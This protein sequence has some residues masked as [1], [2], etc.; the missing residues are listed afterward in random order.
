[1]QKTPR[2]VAMMGSVDKTKRIV[3]AVAATVVALAAGT[4]VR[5][6]FSSC[7]LSYAG[8]KEMGN[9]LLTSAWLNTVCILGMGTSVRRTDENVIN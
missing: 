7:F 5:P 6:P 8:E 1:M 9:N 3:S 4:N 2:K